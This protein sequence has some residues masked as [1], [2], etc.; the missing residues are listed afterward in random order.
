MSDEDVAYA[1]VICRG[2][3]VPG[4][5]SCGQVH[6]SESEYSRQMNRPD[7]LWMCP[8][9]GSTA[10]FDDDYFEEL[11]GIADEEAP[12]ELYE[13]VSRLVRTHGTD[14]IRGI[15]DGLDAEAREHD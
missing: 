3:S 8:H 15:C 5:K 13:A 6:I 1:A 12:D 10:H 2:D 4:Q 11:H 9:C 14:V 7:S